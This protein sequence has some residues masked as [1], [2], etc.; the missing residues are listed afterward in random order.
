MSA[1]LKSV[2]ICSSCGYQSPKWNGKCHSCGEC[3]SYRIIGQTRLRKF[4]VKVLEGRYRED[5][6]SAE[7]NLEALQH[8]FPETAECIAQLEVLEPEPVGVC[9]PEC[10]V[11]PIVL[12]IGGGQPRIRSLRIVGR[13]PTISGKDGVGILAVVPII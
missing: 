11:L 3:A 7:E 10:G 9:H 4:R 1:K 5:I 6:G 12:R 2:Y 8:R 13:V